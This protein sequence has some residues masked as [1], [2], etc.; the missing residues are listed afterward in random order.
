MTLRSL[1]HPRSTAAS[2]A[3]TAVAALAVLAV[4]AAACTA[5]DT[6]SDDGSAAAAE[7]GDANGL[8]VDGPDEGELINAAALEE[9][10]FTVTATGEEPSVDALV[11]LLDGD[12]V[13]SQAE[14]A[15]DTLTYT[16]GSLPD[17]E[18][19]L[20]VA[21]PAEGADAA[22][23]ADE[24]AE[25]ADAADGPAEPEEL[26]SWRFEVKAEPPTLELTAP[27]GAV[28]EDGP[29]T[30]AGTTE[31]GA[32]VAVGS[33]DV[34]ADDTGAFELEVGEVGD[35][36]TIVV[37]DVAG[38]TTEVTEQVVRV[39]SRV[40][41]D[42]IRTVHATFWA[43]A[44]PSLREP[45]VEMLDDGK[46]NSLQ[47]DLKDEGGHLGYA[48]E[49]P[50]ASEI[51]ADIGPL[52]LEQAVADLHDRDVAVIGRIVAFA[53]PALASW[54]WENDRRDMV[55]QLKDGSDYYRG[56]YAGF[57][58]YTH[59]DVIDYLLDIAEEAAQ[60][61]VDHIL[62]DYIRRPEGLDNYT[63]P[64]LETTPEEAI[65]EFTRLADERLAPYGIQ[66]GASVY[67]IAAD[68]PTQIGQDIPAMAEHLDYV[69]PMIYPSHWGV[70]EYGV[71]DP[72]RQPYDIVTATLEVWE[73]ATEGKRARV[74]PWLEDT[75]Y[76]AWDRP[77]QIREQIRAT[78][79]AGIDEW[80]MWNP[81]STFTPEAYESR[82]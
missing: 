78:Q 16:P 6:S 46:I 29:V 77:L 10:T 82:G 33:D 69:A 40:H 1:L 7:D 81:G 49:V 2:T 31:A 3:L 36:L 12:D 42:E 52:D 11:L 38:N 56:S 5:D 57:S 32:T 14:L 58:N 19:E 65:V 48:S 20:V 47:L 53:D 45:I 60:A 59:E 73:E 67:G 8:R 18:R 28:G 22:E 17:G 70:G 43:W 75:P 62:W 50:L 13:T 27:D 76:R 41:L 66:H 4:V 21:T 39:A 24:A 44:T 30:V 9:L 51:G 26:H 79:D 55:I 74:I 80:L 25:G 64:G 54:A 35:E 61:G 63:V 37:T 72:N 71:A 15:Q 34:T 68:R 23:D